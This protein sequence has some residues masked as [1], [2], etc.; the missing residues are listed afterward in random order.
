MD[1]GAYNYVADDTPVCSSR[2]QL[3]STKL[4]DDR[5]S[6]TNEISQSISTFNFC[7][8]PQDAFISV[9]AP[10]RSGKSTL[11]ESMIH[12]FRK[13]HKVDA[14]LLFTKTDAG[15]YQIPKQYRFRNLDPLQEIIDA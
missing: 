13:K 5:L 15:F 8:I 7:N 9:I 3:S 1:N 12:D 10:R 6:K 11:V 2:A 14:V 4:A